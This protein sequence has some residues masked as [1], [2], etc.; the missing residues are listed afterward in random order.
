L[1]GGIERLRFNEKYDLKDP[2]PLK[3]RILVDAQFF[4]IKDVVRSAVT[5]IRTGTTEKPDEAAIA[6]KVKKIKF[7]NFILHLH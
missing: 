4:Q 1:F 6:A 2:R 5:E 3:H 7:L